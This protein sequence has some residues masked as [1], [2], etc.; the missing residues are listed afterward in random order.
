MFG[1]QYFV[2]RNGCLYAE[3]GE[4]HDF[5]GGRRTAE[6]WDAYFGQNNIRASVERSISAAYS[7]RYCG[8]IEIAA[9]FHVHCSKCDGSRTAKDSSL[10]K[11]TAD[12]EERLGALAR[13]V[14]SLGEQGVLD[15]PKCPNQGWYTAEDPELGVVHQVQ[16]EFCCCEPRSK[17]NS[18][19]ATA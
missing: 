15:C 19:K 16:C 11:T 10:K 2:E 12:T 9:G 1:W 6:E 7:C 13:S 14:A 18:I 5:D 17:F 4:C 3:N 8:H